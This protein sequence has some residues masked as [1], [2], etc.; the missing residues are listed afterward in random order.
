MEIPAK[1]DEFRQYLVSNW[2]SADFTYVWGKREQ[3]LKAGATTSA[4]EYLALHITRHLV[5]REMIKD[6]RMA[7][8]HDPLARE[9]YEAKTIS[10]L[11]DINESQIV[12]SLR[13]KIRAEMEQDMKPAPIMEG[14]SSNEFADLKI[15]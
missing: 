9:E 2:T 15:G 6:G 3:T 8:L 5:N 7:K 10:L 4:P 12:K 13:D 14:A 1:F 11:G